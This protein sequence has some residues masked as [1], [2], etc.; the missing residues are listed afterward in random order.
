MFG[1]KE[2][3]IRYDVAVNGL[4]ACGLIRKLTGAKHACL[5]SFYELR[6]ISSLTK[7][8]FSFH[9]F[10]FSPCGICF[11]IANRLMLLSGKVCNIT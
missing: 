8:F 11:D 2:N 4:L 9:P 1:L 6:D 7:A 10:S 3:P 5:P